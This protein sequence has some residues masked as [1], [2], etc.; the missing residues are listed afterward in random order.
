MAPEKLAPESAI[1]ERSFVFKMSNFVILP[2]NYWVYFHFF[3][4]IIYHYLSKC[5]KLISIMH[6][7]EKLNRRLLC[8]DLSCW[9]T[10]IN[11]KY[12]IALMIWDDMRMMNINHSSIYPLSNIFKILINVVDYFGIKSIEQW[13]RVN[14]FFKWIVKMP[15]A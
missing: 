11:W 3:Y 7:R 6:Y 5:C 9:T 2:S 8:T 14:D 4:M 13:N 15:S 12:I 10:Y 1:C